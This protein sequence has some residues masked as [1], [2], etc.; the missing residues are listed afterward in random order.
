MHTELLRFAEEGAEAVDGVQLF[1]PAVYDIVWSIVVL[2]LI[3]GILGLKV[4][5]KL[6]AVLDERAELIEGGI[7]KAENAQAEADKA[8]EEY[9]AQLT[10]ARAEAARIREDAR[11]EATQIAAEARDK[12]TAESARIA[13]TAVKQIEA[14]RQQALVALRTDV[15]ALATELA[16][17]IVG[18]S[19]ADDARQTRVIDTF[20]D[21]L[22]KTMETK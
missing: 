11:A 14:E 5:P 17:R 18:E 10:E 3:G 16:S 2:L 22:E 20:M 7:K 19:L 13:E 9:T 8:L 1:I 21:E 4:F 15:G 12:A 6:R